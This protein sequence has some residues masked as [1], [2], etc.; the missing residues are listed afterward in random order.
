MLVAVALALGAVAYSVWPF[1]SG[2]RMPPGFEPEPATED[3]RRLLELEAH[4]ARSWSMAAGEIAPRS[5]AEGRGSQ[6]GD[7]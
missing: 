5:P 1:R 4:A 7:R 2:R 6:G 3:L